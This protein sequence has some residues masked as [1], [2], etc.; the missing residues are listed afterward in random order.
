V[1]IPSTGDNGPR[2]FE[3]VYPSLAVCEIPGRV[4]QWTPESITV[5]GTGFKKVGDGKRE[6]DE[7]GF[8]IRQEKKTIQNTASD[9]ITCMTLC[10]NNPACKALNFRHGSGV[11]ELVTSIG[12]T[13][14]FNTNLSAYIK[15]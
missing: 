6:S 10:E 15:Q 1:G 12:T 5:N 2:N 9:M 13:N 8:R 4:S 11:C 14:T 3:S 7:Y